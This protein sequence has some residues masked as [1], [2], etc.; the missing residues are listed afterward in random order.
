MIIAIEERVFVSLLDSVSCS[1]LM[2]AHV[3]SQGAYR[4]SAQ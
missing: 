4:K 3:A 2:E 1:G